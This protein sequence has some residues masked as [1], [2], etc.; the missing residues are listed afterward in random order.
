M[1]TI[2]AIGMNEAE[3]CSQSG[4]ELGRVQGI[5][6]GTEAITDC[7]AAGLERATGVPASMWINLQAEYDKRMI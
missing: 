2:D 5:L 3:L 6:G 4:I 7:D 1:E